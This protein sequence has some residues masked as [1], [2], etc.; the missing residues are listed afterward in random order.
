MKLPGSIKFVL[1]LLLVTL[2]GTK[3]F[4]SQV[5]AQDSGTWRFDAQVTEV[6]KNAE[7]SRQLLYWYFT[8]PP[9]QTVAQLRQIWSLSRNVVLAIFLLVIAVT[10]LSYI[11]A[12]RS[13]MVGSIF[14]GVSSP[15]FGLSI[16]TLFFRIGILLLY[17]MFS[18][19]LVLGLIQVGESSS[20]FFI[21]KFQGCQLFNIRFAGS[22]TRCSLQN[23][24]LKKMEQNYINF[25]GYKDPNPLN[26]ESANTAML[27]VRLTSFTYNL[28]AIVLILR[29]VILWFLLM[30][31]PFLAIL[32]PFLFI[33]NT[34]YI[35][36]GVFFQWLFYQ[37]LVALFLAGLAQIWL[38]GIPFTF[39]FSRVNQSDS[40]V[41]PT[42]INI[43]Y[44][45][46]AQALTPTNSANYIDT[47]A[48]YLIAL[49]MLWAAI[50]LPWLLLRIFRDYCCDLL[51]QN[52]AVLLSILDRIRGVGTAPSP[53][54]LPPAGTT[55]ISMQLP[56][57]KKV[58]QVNKVTIKEVAQI[59]QLRTEDL[60]RSLSLSVSSLTD[61]ARFE[62][63]KDSRQQTTQTLNRI[64]NPYIIPQEQD[65]EQYVQI[66][67]ELEDRV[68]AG[69]KLAGQMLS[70]I[71]QKPLSVTPIPLPLNYH[72]IT[73]KEA[74]NTLSTKSQI[75]TDTI[76]EIL[77]EI[78]QIAAGNQVR[79]LS[80][81]FK[82][83]TSS[84]EKLI[85]LLP[86][87]T[88][89]GTDNLQLLSEQPS[90]AT[91]IAKK[92]GLTED[93]VRQI[94]QVFSE[95][96][97]SKAQRVD[98]ISQKTTV[99][100]KKVKEVLENIP[101]DQLA[102]KTAITD[103]GVIDR[104]A[105]NTSLSSNIVSE[106]VN[107]ATGFVPLKV[108]LEDQI[109]LVSEVAGISKQK[110]EEILATLSAV[111]LEKPLEVKPKI[112]KKPLVSVEDYEEVK[113]MWV[114]HYKNS[115]V[116]LTENIKNR[117]DWVNEDIRLLTNTLNLLTSL[118]PADK[119]KGMKQVASILPFL[120]LGGFSEV[121]TVVYLKAKLKAA[122][123]ILTQLEEREK[124]K[125]ELKKQEEESLI[126]VPTGEKKEEE[127]TL[128]ETQ[129]QALEFPKKADGNNS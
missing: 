25:E 82:V 57:R 97:S 127:K 11:I 40:Q 113:N 74:F 69:D 112:A 29:Q 52:N 84:I 55:G 58:E 16:P 114:N 107:A 129:K 72:E 67:K 32:L 6:G 66:K 89:K 42:S 123:M 108:N 68:V 8:H 96:S 120:L 5:F 33:R 50:F 12:R 41:F 63:N 2:V 13:N 122:Q 118:N 38:S 117:Q 4:S 46:P 34:G 43:L 126:E 78:P 87:F 65:R 1:I 7:R 75:T 22:G 35:W 103:A 76:R 31:S 100:A 47:Y 39:D 71:L 20:R 36:I 102:N 88:A 48:E 115:E 45:G 80:S 92:T 125:E 3:L 37:P 21:E 49:V 61:V 95:T 24:E 104:I 105:L 44:G 64:A 28:L 128:E 85:S 124:L 83:A 106:I 15:I 77:R 109:D 18:Y 30:L 9:S 59:S 19:V 119:E 54:T 116:P 51:R 94:I 10:G 110:V 73:V 121:E 101:A 70:A 90:L 111:N 17:I 27:L 79:E 98:K 86:Q 53:P 62:M 14:N 23:D 93:K 56:F 99:S 60:S 26:Q 91:G 81:R